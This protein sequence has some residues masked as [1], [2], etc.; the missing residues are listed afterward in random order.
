MRKLESLVIQ[1]KW[2]RF[3]LLGKQR[4]LEG[5][6]SR[7]IIHR[8]DNSPTLSKARERERF[9]LNILLILIEG[10]LPVSQL[11]VNQNCYMKVL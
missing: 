2:T 3:Y 11:S 8:D 5:Q 6:V 7:T 10:L 1:C 4:A 9:S